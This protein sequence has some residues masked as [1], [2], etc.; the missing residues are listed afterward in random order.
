MRKKTLSLALALA[1]CLGL[2]AVPAS[3]ASAT[4]KEVTPAEALQ[5]FGYI[6]ELKFHDSG[7]VWVKGGA[8][9]TAGE[10][11]VEAGSYGKTTDFY[12]G[13]AWVQAPPDGRLACIDE[14][15]RELF[16]IPHDNTNQLYTF[17]EGLARKY[18]KEDNAYGYIN[19]KG[20]T[21]IPYEHNDKAGYF[22]SGLAVVYD[23]TE[24]YYGYIDT[25]G[26][27]VIPYQF[28]DAK[29]F[30]NGVAPVKLGNRQTVIDTTGKDLLPQEYSYQSIISS[31]LVLA[32]GKD[33]YAFF[34]R[35]GQMV[36][37][38]YSSVD[39][40][41]FNFTFS[42]GMIG[43]IKD[44][45]LG[46]VNESGELAVPCQFYQTSYSPFRDGFAVVQIDK[47]GKTYGI[48]DKS[49]RVMGPSVGSHAGNGCFKISSNESGRTRYGFKDYTGKE[50]VPCTYAEVK[51]FSG[52][53]APVKKFDNKWGFV[54]TDGTE[55]VPCKYKNI[56]P[57]NVPG[58]FTVEDDSGYSIW[59]ASG[60][61]APS[62]P[63]TPT[64]PTTPTTPSGTATANP[65][66]D[67][68]TSDGVLQN[69]TV[70]K[71]GDSNY[72]KIRD[73]AAILN[74]TGKQ[75]SVGYDN[76]KQSVTATT[77]QGYTKLD[78]DLA[79]APAGQETA[80][81]SSDAIYV[82][83][84]KVEA[85]VYKI[86]GNNYFK[87]R[88]LGKALNFYVGWSQEQGMFID[89]SKPYSE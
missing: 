13:V 43:V 68:L 2:M 71:I 48:I 63:T 54:D 19:K 29:D 59:K 78:G 26:K 76:E 5:K 28:A 45:K 25:T 85:E 7:I 38:G 84:Q 30:D 47:E 88:D 6:G 35:A 65:T 82:N 27:V 17:S 21:V 52:G 40:Y 67:K 10:V 61:T 42:D 55:I 49:G 37:G 83:G 31:E 4:V 72:F 75:F 9:N 24:A 66:N 79:G 11:I 53:V 22:H 87:L 60:W 46:Y 15:G 51:D 62:T 81:A 77:G 32:Y 69:P 34:N 18:S 58:I 74:G 14:S 89:T 70:Y 36:N 20:E 86:G 16:S 12:D 1:T 57:S 73:L 41:G 3:A 56:T 50:I 23:P 80:E 39:A 44:G 33:G 64:E 8:I